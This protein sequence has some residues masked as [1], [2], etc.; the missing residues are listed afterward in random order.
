MSCLPRPISSNNTERKRSG[1]QKKKKRR[2]HRKNLCLF[3]LLFREIRIIG[4][5]R[6]SDAIRNLFFQLSSFIFVELG[7]SLSCLVSEEVWE[8]GNCILG[9]ERDGVLDLAVKQ[10]ENEADK[11]KIEIN[12]QNFVYQ[13]FYF[14]K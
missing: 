8:N 1:G 14:E 3:K 4:R 11:K 13:S 10:N 5:L 7:I 12:G 6:F 2:N 9:E